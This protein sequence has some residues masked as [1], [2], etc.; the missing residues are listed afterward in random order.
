VPR[1][2][3]QGRRGRYKFVTEKDVEVEITIARQTSK[4]KSKAVV[5]DDALIMTVADGSVGKFKRVK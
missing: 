2:C 4:T 1:P 5:S 3:D